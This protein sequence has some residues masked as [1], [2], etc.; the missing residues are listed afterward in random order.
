MGEML[1]CTVL[2]ECK[3]QYFHSRVSYIGKHFVN[4]FGDKTQ[5]L[6]NDVK[7]AQCFFSSFE[8]LCSRTFPPFAV[9][10][11][12]ITVRNSVVAFKSS[13]MVYSYYIVNGR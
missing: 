8:K 4:V 10:C 1:V 13:E 6:G 7:F 3:L 9:F 2:A 11:G 5:I 12:F